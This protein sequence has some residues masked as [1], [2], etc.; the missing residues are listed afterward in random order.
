MRCRA[1]DYELW[2]C[3]GRVCPECGDPFSLKDFEFEEDSVL[4]HCP[5]CNH[6]V[7]GHGKNGW[8]NLN[9]E[10]CAGC[11][12][13]VGLDYYIVRPVAGIDEATLGGVLPNRTKEGNWFSRYFRTVWLVMTKPNRTMGRIPIHEPLTKAWGFLMT[14]CVVTIIGSV[15]S[16]FSISAFTSAGAGA[17]LAE[18]LLLT[19][20][21]VGL[22]FVILVL[23]VCAWIVTTHVILLMS[24]GCAFTLRRTA[25][26]ILYG[27]GASI[28]NIIP[29]V[30]GIGGTVWW[31]VSAINMVSRGQRVSGKRASLAVL[32]APILLTLCCFGGWVA[33]TYTVVSR[34]TTP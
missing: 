18:L 17:G 20:L 13:A 11:G 15:L 26:A 32:G 14:T 34:Y 22:F 9:I 30:G 31:I 16:A 12:L 27:G 2:H 19:I 6:G 8:P 24:G 29:C 21:Q 23:Y 10:Q 4:F 25:Q 1:C 5:H 33:L 3:T 28:V 7:E